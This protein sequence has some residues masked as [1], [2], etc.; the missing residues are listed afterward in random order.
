[1][2]DIIINKSKL[3]YDLSEQEQNQG[4]ERRR[5]RRFIL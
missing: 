2:T 3:I 4:D 1:M 5:V